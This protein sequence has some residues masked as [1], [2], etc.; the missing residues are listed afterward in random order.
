M[1]VLGLVDTAVAGH[2]PGAHHLAAVG[3]GAGFAGAV[4]FLFGFLRMGTTGLVA[5]AHGAGDRREVV[6]RLLRALL[7]AGAAG[8]LLLLASPALLA[9]AAWIY[10]PDARL[11]PELEGYLAFRLAGAPAALA[12]AVVY[13]WLLGTADART[14]LILLVGINGLN[15][16]LDLVFVFGLGMTAPGIGLATAVAE[17]CGALAALLLVRHRSGALSPVLRSAGFRAGAAFRALFALNRDLFLRSALLE[18]AFVL[19]GVV[20]ARLGPVEAAANAV[21]FNVFTLSAY[22]LDGFAFAAES[23]VGRAV[24]ARDPRALRAAEAAAFRHAGALAT[25]ASLAFWLAGD[26]LVA[27]LTDLPEVRTAASALVPLAGAV[28]LVAVWAFVYDGIFI[29]ATRARELRDGM[30]V[31]FGLYLLLLPPLVAGFGNAGLWAALLA[32]LA[33]RGLVL[34]RLHERAV[35]RPAQPTVERRDEEARQGPVA[36][37]FDADA[38]SGRP[39]RR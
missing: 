9:A 36:A 5:Q 13:G 23:L 30:A 29:G 33:A 22:G 18:T 7:V 31:S 8:A 1:P 19:F 16:V 4:F 39:R 12:V 17:W 34:H 10:A 38:Q 27:L 24:G 26:A 11:A 3:L 20:G 28:P 37:A 6:V 14:S 25:L 2:L 35:A 32:F 15:A 21:L